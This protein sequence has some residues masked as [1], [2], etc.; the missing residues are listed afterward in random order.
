M[1]KINNIGFQVFNKITYPNIINF[2]HDLNIPIQKSN[3]S[4]SVVTNFLSWG[5]GHILS[6]I[7]SLFNF[8]FIILLYNMWYFHYDANKFIETE[9]HI[10]TVE[11]FCI[12]YKYNSYFTEGY[13]IPFCSAVW[14]S[15][16]DESKNFMAFPTLKFMKNHGLLSFR[17]LQWYT[18][19]NRSQDYI[20]N[21]LSKYSDRITIIHKSPEN[22]K[23]NYVDG[24][25]YDHIIFACHGNNIIN[26][27][28]NPKK[29]QIEVLNKFIF[30]KSKCYLHSDLSLMPSNKYIWSSWNFIKSGKKSICTYWCNK[31]QCDLTYKNLFF[32]LNF[33]KKPQNSL[34]EIDFEHPIMNKSTIEAQHEISKIQGKDNF[35][36]VGAYLAN[37]FHEDGVVSSLKVV[38]KLLSIDIPILK[39]LVNNYSNYSYINNIIIFIFKRIIKKG[40]LSL[41]I[42]NHPI[43]IIQ[44]KKIQGKE[45]NIQVI[46]PYLFLKALLNHNVGF[47]E[48]YI[49][50]YFTTT[51][52]KELLTLITININSSELLKSISYFKNLYTNYKI[53][54][55]TKCTIFNSITNIEKHYDLSNDLYKSFLDKTMTYSS[56]IFKNL[57]VIPDNLELAQ[58]NKYN[59]IIKKLNI[60]QNDHILEIGCGWGGFAIHA[61]L[62]TKCKVTCITLSKNQIVYFKEKIKNNALLEKNIEILFIDYR[63]ITGLYD[64]IVSIEMVEAVGFKYIEDYFKILKKLIKPCGQIMIQSICIPDKRLYSYKNSVDF[65]QKYIFPGGFLPSIGLINKYSDKYGLIVSDIKNITTDYADTLSIWKINFNHNYKRIENN[66]FNLRFKLIWNYYLDYCEVGFRTNMVQTYQIIFK[67]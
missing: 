48:A 45:A 16:P 56:A 32:T 23:P 57:E 4:F 7:L 39:P 30:S 49:N 21:I 26:L 59:R 29:E 55:Q 61:V 35:W 12:K 14:S 66:Q 28:E 43:T 46:N 24:K 41:Q 1:E 63:N 8:S 33:D 38:N 40:K 27:L 17:K 25:Y 51:N 52:L 58:K 31:I 3:M 10:T 36:Y 20:D 65:I 60:T 62:T 6:I 44:C 5:T 34:L 19:S 54:I 67:I 13:L 22:I 53:K 11:E 42:A 18:L 37:G 47:G 2:F 50:G 64:K 9:D 15:S